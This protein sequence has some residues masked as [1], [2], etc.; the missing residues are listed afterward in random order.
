LHVFNHR[1]AGEV[2]GFFTEGHIDEFIGLFVARILDTEAVAHPRIKGGEI[3]VFAG[4]DK[5]AE[6]SDHHHVGGIGR[7]DKGV[8]IGDVS[9]LIIGDGRAVGVVGG[10]Q[11]GRGTGESE[12]GGDCRGEDEF[13]AHKVRGNDFFIAVDG[14]LLKVISFG[15]FTLPVGSN[16]LP[17]LFPLHAHLAQNLLSA[18]PCATCRGRGALFLVAGQAPRPRTVSASARRSNAGP[19][20]PPGAC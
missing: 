15:I 6:G 13:R 20:E 19:A 4:H 18:R 2:H 17:V 8:Y 11:R 14:S 9:A 7:I 5:T 16:P 12:G 10:A 1:A 3:A